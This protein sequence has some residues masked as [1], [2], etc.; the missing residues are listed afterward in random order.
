MLPRIILHSELLSTLLGIVTT[1]IIS[2]NYM[3]HDE[4]IVIQIP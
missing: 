2:L 1:G 4:S 3:I